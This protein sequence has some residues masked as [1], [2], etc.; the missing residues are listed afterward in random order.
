MLDEVLYT[1]SER[2]TA[3][4]KNLAA[5]PR[6]VVHLESAND[7]VIVRGVMD[8]VGHPRDAAHVVA[9]LDRKYS[10]PGDA[11]YL[12]SGDPD[13]DVVYAFRP[14]HAM[15]WRLDDWEGSQ[16]RWSADETA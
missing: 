8:D 15:M 4:A 10:E 3:K 16:R 5:D 6:A 1:Y 12:P 9:A 2:R 11:A 13:F 14:R 7:V